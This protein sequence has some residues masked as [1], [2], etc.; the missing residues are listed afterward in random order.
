MNSIAVS[1][2]ALISVFL[3]LKWGYLA[4]GILAGLFF[5]INSI[6]LKQIDSES[7]RIGDRILTWGTVFIIYPSGRVDM[8]QITFLI[9]IMIAFFIKKMWQTPLSENL[10][11]QNIFLYLEATFITCLVIHT[12]PYVPFNKIPLY[13]IGHYGLTASFAFYVYL[14]LLKILPKKV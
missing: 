11:L 7:G 1:V 12:I 9:I 14:V 4:T 6:I 3:F 2:A 13:Y 10:K 8:L 5:L